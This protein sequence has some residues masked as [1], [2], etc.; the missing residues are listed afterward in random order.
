MPL[1]FV[2]MVKSINCFEH[3]M[4]GREGMIDYNTPCALT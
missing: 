3:E 2:V 1:L 4:D